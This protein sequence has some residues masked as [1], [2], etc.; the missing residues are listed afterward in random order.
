[1]RRK[2][3]ATEMANS[4]C[5]G[6]RIVGVARFADDHAPR[7][8]PELGE[9]REVIG[10]AGLRQAFGRNRGKVGSRSHE[11]LIPRCRGEAW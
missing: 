4:P 8:L 5:L 10:L 6:R 11:A 9:Q 1:M 3:S 2:A 7:F